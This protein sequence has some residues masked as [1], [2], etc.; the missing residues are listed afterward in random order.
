MD[1]RVALLLQNLDRAFDARSW[2]GTT[3]KG[4]L[5]GLQADVACWK[6]R[7]DRNS[8]WQLVLHAA[9]WKYIVRRALTEDEAARF[10]RSPSNFP[11]VPEPPTQAALRK[12]VAL[13]VQEHR[14]LRDAVAAFPGT[15]LDRP[16]G[17]GRG[18]TP[19]TLILGAA[20]HDLYHAGQIQ[21]LKRLHPDAR[22]KRGRR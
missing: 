10:P 14:R 22:A 17:S 8:I 4:S 15:R 1:A 9:Y 6:P 16:R 5:R 3:L 12:D 20:A 18:P 2:H 13:L 19:L 11:R 21:L 7:A